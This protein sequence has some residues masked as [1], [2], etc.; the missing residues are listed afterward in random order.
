IEL[1]PKQNKEKQTSA[2]TKKPVQTKSKDDL[3]QTRI[4]HFKKLLRISGIRL[5]I[6]RTELDQFKS[7]KAKIDYLKSL[8]DKGGFT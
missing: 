1:S 6:K 5:I 4:E 3:A 2:D 7:N 8:F